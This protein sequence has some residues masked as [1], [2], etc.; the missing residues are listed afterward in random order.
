MK[1]YLHLETTRWYRERGF[2]YRR[3]YL[4]YGPLGTGKTSLCLATASS[5]GI[6]IYILSLNSIGENGLALL[7]QALLRRYMV[8][9]EDIDCAGIYKR[10]NATQAKLCED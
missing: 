9:F 2:Y 1:D 6:D 4:F 3:T 5:F 10:R 7:F 8:L